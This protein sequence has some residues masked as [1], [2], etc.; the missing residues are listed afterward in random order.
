MCLTFLR[1]R[2]HFIQYHAYMKE[3]RY[4]IHWTTHTQVSA[5]KWGCLHIRSSFT[6]NSL[7]YLPYLFNRMKLYIELSRKREFLT[8]KTINC[9]KLFLL[10]L[11][12]FF[13]QWLSSISIFWFFNLTYFVHEVVPLVLA[14]KWPKE[15]V[16]FFI[17]S[18]SKEGCLQRSIALLLILFLTSLDLCFFA[19]FISFMFIDLV[20]LRLRTI[21]PC[22]LSWLV[23]RDW[24]D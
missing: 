22:A 3:S 18:L 15:W 24:R 5:S 13:N 20:S 12:L 7:Y 14:I 9:F 2:L 16:I 17:E 4:P 6:D 10:L 23:C 21:L 19:S 8:T 11:E 1:L